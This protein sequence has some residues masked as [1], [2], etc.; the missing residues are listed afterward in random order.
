MDKDKKWLKDYDQY[1]AEMMSNITNSKFKDGE[2]KYSKA[3]RDILNQTSLAG[4]SGTLIDVGCGGGIWSIVL[5]KWYHVYG[6][7]NSKM[8]IEHAKKLYVKHKKNNNIKYDINFVCDDVFNIAGRKF[9]IAY[10]RSPEFFG[11]F[12]V[13]SDEF[14]NALEFLLSITN[15]KLVLSLA[16]MEPFD[17]YVSRY[18]DQ[19]SKEYFDGA[20]SY[21]HDPKKIEA[22]FK[23]YGKTKVSYIPGRITAELEI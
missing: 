18:S 10:C 20:T 13:E 12:P 8:A 11:A 7:D 9:D 15:K 19:T 17:R 23:K 16:S 1:Y 6:V 3:E 4:G 22:L 2:Y 14:I 5:S 21:F